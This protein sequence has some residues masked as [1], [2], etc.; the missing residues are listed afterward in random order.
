M[1]GL[2]NKLHVKN[3][4]VHD[5]PI[6]IEESVSS[7][8]ISLL[9]LWNTYADK[10]YLIHW[11]EDKKL[12]LI[13]NS[14]IAVFT[15]QGCGEVELHDGKTYDLQGGSVIFLEPMTIKHYFCKG[16][17]WNLF[18]I[19]FIPSGAMEITCEEI[20]HL[21]ALDSLTIDFEKMSDHLLSDKASFKKLA[22]ASLTKVLYEWLCLIETKPRE[23]MQF[24]LVQKVIS[25][26]N[27][28]LSMRWTV[29][30][31]ARCAGCSEQ[32]LRRLFLKFTKQT[33]KEYILNTKL[34]AAVFLM[35]KKYCNV[36]QV[37]Q[38]LNF[39]DA[40]HFSKSFKKKFGYPPSRLVLPKKSAL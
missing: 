28:K 2:N 24:S 8:G 31:M 5:I 39:Y 38:E 23:D 19:E 25:E 6:V 27:L 3:E 26:I 15:V 40:F 18:W 17:I 20:I 4:L 12:P 30:D 16:L 34:S 21:D 29:T 9:A 33:P 35:E 32:H 7:S 13:S 37:A 1:N 14:T 22:A 11:P 36:N 10:N